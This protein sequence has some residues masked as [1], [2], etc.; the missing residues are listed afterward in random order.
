MPMILVI[1]DDEHFRS[2]VTVLLRR[3][4]YD[5]RALADGH[6]AKALVD[7]EPIDAIIT[8][9]YMPV[10]DGI[11]VVCAVRRSRPDLP[12]FGVTGGGGGLTEPCMRAMRI[13]GASNVVSKPLDA[14]AFLK[15]V[16]GA[17]KD[18]AHNAKS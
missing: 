13:L 17:L 1:D 5:V 8:D 16:D 10:A 12:I 2:Y 9:L 7:N 18:R 3:A 11:E 15:M 6:Q 4:G 14:P